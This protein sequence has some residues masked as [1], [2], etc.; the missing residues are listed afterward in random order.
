MGRGW[1]SFEVHARN[2][3]G[4]DNS[5][6]SQKEMRNSLLETGEKM[7]F[8][9]KCQITEAEISR[10]SIEGTAWILLTA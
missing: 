10:Q 8:V 4:K 9:M 7:I 2:V 3:V 5:R 6:E 1:M